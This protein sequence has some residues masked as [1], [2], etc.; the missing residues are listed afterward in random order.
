VLPDEPV[1]RDDAIFGGHRLEEGMTRR[2]VFAPL[3][4]AKG[5]ASFV[6][7]DVG[8]PIVSDIDIAPTEPSRI[9]DGGGEDLDC[10]PVQ[11]APF[12]RRGVVQCV[13]QR[14][15]HSQGHDRRSSGIRHGNERSDEL[16][17]PP[18]AAHAPA[19]SPAHAPV[20]VHVHAR[21]FAKGREN[22]L[23]RSGGSASRAY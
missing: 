23:R 20:L 11:G 10:V 18:K 19:L 4:R 9:T 5:Y 14:A 22:R 15:A 12:S 2:Q 13:S 17:H 16:R 21:A 8:A 6:A 7:A 3:L 1:G